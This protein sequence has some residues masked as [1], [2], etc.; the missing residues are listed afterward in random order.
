MQ[1]G[2]ITFTATRYI[3]PR[4]SA[5]ARGFTRYIRLLSLKTAL[6][7]KRFPKREALQTLLHRLC[8]KKGST[9]LLIAAGKES[10]RT[11]LHNCGVGKVLSK[12][13][14]ICLAITIAAKVPI[15][16]IQKGKVT[17]RLNAKMTP[18]TTADKSPIEFG[19]FIIRLQSL[20][21]STAV[22][23]QNRISSKALIPK[24]T[25]DAAAAGGGKESNKNMPP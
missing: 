13:P 5:A 8:Y 6:Y 21:Q 17:G 16:A 3:T 14:K 22:T 19:L 11:I 25:T 24:I 7:K 20:S 9:Q 1:Q 2:E 4:S 12:P 18:V 23:A 10:I 15:A